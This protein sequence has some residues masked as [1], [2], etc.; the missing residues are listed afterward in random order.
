[1]TRI[2]HAFW[3]GVMLA[4]SAVARVHAASDLTADEIR[5]KSS[6]AMSPPIQYRMK[7]GDISSIVSIKDLGGDLGL[8][9]RIESVGP[10][11][12]KVTLITA[13]FTYEWWPKAGLAIDKTALYASMR[14][15]VAG[16][17]LPASAGATNRL[18][19][20]EAIDGVEHYVIETTIPDALDQGLAKKL[21]VPQIPPGTE[22]AWINA[23][24]FTLRKTRTAIGDQDVLDITRGIDLPAGRFL[25]PDGMIFRNVGTWEQYQQALADAM[26]PRVAPARRVVVPT[27]AP[28]IWDP[29]SKRWKGSA[30]TGWT[31]E[32]WDAKVESMPSQPIQAGGARASPVATKEETSHRV[33]LYGNVVLVAAL[34]AYA[35][36]R[37]WAKLRQSTVSPPDSTCG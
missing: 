12:E 16:L 37:Q 7:A 15:E 14:E 4:A 26:I 22:R 3:L 25:P 6:E 10:H 29:V 1:M 34:S 36:Y 30:P 21:S 31:Q 2:L 17:R 27:K 32:E 9:T 24:T 23:Q 11:F 35:I 20:S 28:P 33:I 5:A 13:R 18:V 19:D 8:A